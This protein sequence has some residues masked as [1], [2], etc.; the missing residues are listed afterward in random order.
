VFNFLARKNREVEGEK[1]IG[2]LI[3]LKPAFATGFRGDV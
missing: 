3:S 1:Q 2:S